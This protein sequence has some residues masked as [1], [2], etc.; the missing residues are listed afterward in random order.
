[1]TS[2]LIAVLAVAAILM[3]SAD[4]QSRFPPIGPGSIVPI[5]PSTNSAGA[6]PPPPTA[7]LAG[8]IDLS[9]ATGCNI[10]F[11]LGGIFP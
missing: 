4:A 2:I 9:L 10:P 3:S 5:G 7:C 8:A 1:M 6:A 11:Y